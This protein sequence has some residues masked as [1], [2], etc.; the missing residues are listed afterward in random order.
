MISSNK[1]KKPVN[2]TNERVVKE[3]NIPQIV[4]INEPQVN[5]RSTPTAKDNSN[6]VKVVFA[7]AE[8]KLV[9]GA[10]TGDFVAINVEGTTCYVMTKLVTIYDNP[11]YTANSVAAVI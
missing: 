1:K 5:I 9:K 3:S 11:A 2:V 6:I 10:S 8:F 7:G 4:R